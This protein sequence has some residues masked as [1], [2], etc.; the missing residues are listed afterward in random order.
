VRERG[1]REGEGVVAWE[2]QMRE[3]EGEGGARGTPGRAG[4][5]SAGLQAGTESQRTR[6]L[7]G[8]Q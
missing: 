7:I 8:N 2:K 5:G 1:G 4:L 6:P 3:R